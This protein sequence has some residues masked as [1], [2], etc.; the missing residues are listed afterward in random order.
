MVHSHEFD[1]NKFCDEVGEWS[2]NN[3]G[4]QSCF[5]PLLGMF[6]EVGE[7]FEGSPGA[8]Y[9]GCGD[10]MIFLADYCYRADFDM[11]RVVIEDPVKDH[12]RDDATADRIII[13]IGRVCH[14]V[15]KM[16]QGIRT[17]ENHEQALYEALAQ[18]VL[19]IRSRLPD[20]TLDGLCNTATN[21]WDQVKQR[22]WKKYPETGMPTAV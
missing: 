2:R 8:V 22:D 6:E 1:W 4:D 19:W 12:A 5:I 10:F 17:N 13:A 15:I 21:T 16:R 11:Q 20:G 9:D 14:S 7:L 3:F 18:L